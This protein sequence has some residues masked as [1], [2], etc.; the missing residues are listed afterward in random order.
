MVR[1]LREPSGTGGRQRAHLV[2]T[3]RNYL[4]CSITPV[5]KLSYEAP[6]AN[7]PCGHASRDDSDRA[8][9]S[10]APAPRGRAPRI[11]SS[12]PTTAFRHTSNAGGYATR[13][14]VDGSWL[15]SSFT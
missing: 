14:R 4:C 10:R 1:T 9:R 6:Y 5:P 8:R 7:A 11:R 15:V 3:G 12:T 13:P 2:D